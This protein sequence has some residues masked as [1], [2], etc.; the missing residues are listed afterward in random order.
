MR[1][2]LM[3]RIPALGMVVKNIQR[4]AKSGM[5]EALDGRK[6]FVRAQHAALNTLLQGA[7]ATIAKQWC[8]NFHEY[9]LE[10]G[11]VHG[12]DGDF[13]ILAWIH[14]ELQVAVRDDAHHGNLPQEHHRRR[15]RRRHAVRLPPAGGR[16][17]EV[18]PA[19]VGHPLMQVQTS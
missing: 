4:Q 19:L 18:R 1:R 9:C 7:G 12:W 11:L 17:R 3:T 13:V 16:R 10:D 5:L 15:L 2:R 6:L 14:D 8:V